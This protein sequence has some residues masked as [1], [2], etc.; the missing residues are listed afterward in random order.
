VSEPR[1]PGVTLDQSAKRRAVGDRLQQRRSPGERFAHLSDRLARSLPA[2]RSDASDDHHDGELAEATIVHDVPVSGADG[3]PEPYDQ[4]PAE[5]DD[6]SPWYEETPRFPIVRNGYDCPAVDQHVAQLEHDL[7][8]LER[9]AALL[10]TR[11]RGEEEV[12][13]EI[14]RIGEQTSAILV[15]AHDRA[16]ETTSEAQETAQRML[17][18]ARRQAQD[19][20]DTAERRR[21]ET[22]RDVETLLGRRDQLVADLDALADKIAVVAREASGRAAPAGD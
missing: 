6:L 5:G 15:E 12:R 1:K 11:A 9:E 13:A 14:Q 21:A 17:D 19:I 10:R 2:M 20:T 16:H 7:A 8:E 3:V 18:D 4:A 22:Q